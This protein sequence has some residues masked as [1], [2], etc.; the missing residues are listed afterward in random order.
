MYCPF[1]LLVSQ[2]D[3]IYLTGSASIETRMLSNGRLLVA[4]AET[5]TLEQDETRVEKAKAEMA[6][7][8]QVHP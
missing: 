4:M 1:I 5:S 6:A 3:L 7:F 2:S 8:L